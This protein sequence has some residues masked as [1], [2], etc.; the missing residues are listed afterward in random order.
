MID[1][2]VAAAANESEDALAKLDSES[3]CRH[4]IRLGAFGTPTSASISLGTK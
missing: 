2:L 3:R 4:R 1:A